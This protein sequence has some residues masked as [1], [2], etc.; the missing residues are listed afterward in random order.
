MLQFDEEASRRL[1]ETYRTPDVVAQRR[2]TLEALDPRP[3]ER[4]VDIGSGPG[5][6]AAELAEAVGREG[7]V[8]GVDVSESMNAIARSL[9]RAEGAAPM[10]FVLGD[11][12]AIPLPTGGFDAAVCTQVYEY[13]EDLPAALAEA[14]RVL[15]PGGRLLILDTEWDSLVWHSGDRERMRRV[16]D[17][18][19]E[20]LAHPDLPRRLTALLE[21]AGFGVTAASAFTILNAGWRPD[22]FSAGLTHTIA[23]YVPGHR[24]VTE[25]EAAA[26]A[27]E[28]AGLGRDHF[29]SLTRYLFLATT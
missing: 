23:A 12:L 15:R 21:D 18:W 20:H 22:M 3:G 14:R 5:M 10:E 26:W 2:A 19:E 24:G 27:E 11:A 4:I 17:A 28:L 7:A 29:F 9:P 6:L 8:C 1:V 16:I 25:E 13:V